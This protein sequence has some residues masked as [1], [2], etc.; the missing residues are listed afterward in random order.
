MMVITGY[1]GIMHSI[2]GVISTSKWYSRPELRNHQSMLSFIRGCYHWVIRVGCQS[3]LSLRYQSMLPY[4]P[5]GQKVSTSLKN[6]SGDYYWDMGDFRKLGGAP[7]SN[8]KGWFF[9]VF[10]FLVE[11]PI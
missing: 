6:K 10:F 1:N 11:H 2:N 7:E 8:R 4:H 9:Y 5:L 3:M